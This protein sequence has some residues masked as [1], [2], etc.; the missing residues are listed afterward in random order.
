MS[1]FN[2]NWY[3]RMGIPRSI[4][5]PHYQLKESHN[6]WG[7][8]S[9]MKHGGLELLWCH[10]GCFLCMAQSTFSNV[11]ISVKIQYC[12]CQH[13]CKWYCWFSYERICP[14]DHRRYWMPEMSLNQHISRIVMWQNLQVCIFWWY[15]KC[16]NFICSA[17]YVLSFTLV[18]LKSIMN[19]LPLIFLHI[20]I[21]NIR[22]TQI[23]QRKNST[24]FSAEI[25]CNR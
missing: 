22:Q 5:R 16:E 14:K 9:H 19:L 24:S 18:T 12:N 23:K 3:S 6:N 21:Y 4:L 10:N 8:T 17:N 20:H 25:K 7:D 15:L 1:V 2:M 11:S 13:G